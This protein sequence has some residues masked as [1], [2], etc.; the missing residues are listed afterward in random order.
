M[1]SYLKF[2]FALPL[3]NYAADVLKATVALYMEDES[4]PMPTHEEVLVCN[5]HTTEEK[6]TLLWK[7][8]VGDPNSFRIFSLVHAEKLSYQTCDKALKTLFE[9]TQGCKGYIH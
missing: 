1:S 2:F 8:A 7:R 4:L 5:E 6:I 3:L 9:L